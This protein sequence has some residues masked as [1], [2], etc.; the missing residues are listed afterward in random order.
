MGTYKKLPPESFAYYVSLGIER[1]YE[2]VAERYNCSKVA[3]TNKA[4]KEKWQEQIHELAE[5]ARHRFE[6]DAQ[7]EMNVVRARQLQA[8]RALQGKALEMLRDLKPE[9]AIKAAPALKI[10]WHHELLLLGEPTA[11]NES[12]EE[13][14]RREVHQLLVSKDAEVWGAPDG[15]ADG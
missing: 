14:T 15:S 2:K 7:D 12:V 13:V 4:T 8:A 1:S 3:V 5:Q 9:R 6:I 11:R 10:G